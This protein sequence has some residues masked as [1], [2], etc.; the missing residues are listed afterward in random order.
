MAWTLSAI[1][2]PVHSIC[3]VTSAQHI[4][5]APLLCDPHNLTA[6]AFETQ[7]GK[8]CKCFTEAERVEGSHTHDA[9]SLLTPVLLSLPRR[10]ALL[11]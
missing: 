3:S 10:R 4:L 6:I 8:I 9:S 5:A 2:V 11:S 7:Q 1:Q